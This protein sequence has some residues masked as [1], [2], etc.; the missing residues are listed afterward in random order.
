VRA[1]GRLPILARAGAGLAGLGG[2]KPMGL[3]FSRRVTLFP[4]VRLNFSRSGVSAS[5]GPRGASVTIGPLIAVLDVL[6]AVLAWLEVPRALINRCLA[7]PPDY[8]L[9]YGNTMPA[10]V[11]VR[12][13]FDPR[14]SLARGPD[15]P[16][17]MREDAAQPGSRPYHASHEWPLVDGGRRAMWTDWRAFAASSGRVTRGQA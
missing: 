7:P 2:D 16:Q 4:G 1:S 8:R 6:M 3:R 15:A 12:E 11:T 5:I 17:P 13:P 14:G 9:G 10:A